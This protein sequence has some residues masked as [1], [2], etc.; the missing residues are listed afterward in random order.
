MGTD[1]NDNAVIEWLRS[2]DPAIRWQVL[3]DLTDAP[4]DEVAA[5][6]AKVETEGWGAQLIAAQ[7]PDGQ[8]AGAA[9]FP[10]DFDFNSPD[11]KSP[12]QPWTAT[13]HTLTLLRELGVDPSSEWAQRTVELIGKN[14]RWDRAGEAYWEGEVEACI[15]GRT[16][17]DG[18]YFGVDVSPI[19]ER[20]LGER[21]DDGGWNCEAPHNSTRT[22]FDTTINVVEGLLAYEQATG[23]NDQV[24]AARHGAEEFLLDRHLYRRLSTGE[25]ADDDFLLFRFPTRWQHDVLR[26]LDHFRAA[27]IADSTPPDPRLEPALEVLRSKRTD[28]GRW[29]LDKVPPGREWFDIEKAGEP[30]R[31][32]TLR[33]LRILRWVSN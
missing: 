8:W 23:G 4:E 1:A 2:S 31:W 15:N 12:G 22:S 14:S 30:S 10:A 9:F 3:R 27:G 17:A 19:V 26:G 18:A 33:A 11:A 20:L 32:N 21:L 6:R 29:L 5:E 16:V 28:D 25:P 7:D 13:Y 24:Q